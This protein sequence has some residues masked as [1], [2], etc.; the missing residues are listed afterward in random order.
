MAVRSPR[1]GK[2]MLTVGDTIG[3]LVREDGLVRLVV[4]DLPA[5]GPVKSGQRPG[6]SAAD[7][8]LAALGALEPGEPLAIDFRDVEDVTFAWLDAALVPLVDGRV[9]ALAG[10]LVSV[11]NLSFEVEEALQSALTYRRALLRAGSP[12]EPGRLLGSVSSQVASAFGFTLDRYSFNINELAN[13]L[14]LSL[15]AAGHP[16]RRLLR[17]GAMTRERVRGV[18]GHSYA[19]AT[20]APLPSPDSL[21]L[22]DLDARVEREEPVRRAERS[23]SDSDRD[24]A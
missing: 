17:A 3:A 20:R 5:E 21:W 8:V 23:A 9:T 14:D 4:D 7:V 15:Q 24:R 18:P 2:T 22:D 6:R 1:Y 11:V 19:Y 16:V 12:Y 13:R 10:H